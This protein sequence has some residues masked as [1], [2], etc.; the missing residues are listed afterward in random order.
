MPMQD[1]TALAFE[2]AFAKSHFVGMAAVDRENQAMG[3]IA[4][5]TRLGY[6]EM[7]QSFDLAEGI[8]DQRSAGGQPQASAGSAGVN[9]GSVAK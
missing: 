1:S 7:K 4:E 9:T 2:Q 6:L 3:N 5:Q 8:L